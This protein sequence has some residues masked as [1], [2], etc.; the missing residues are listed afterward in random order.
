MSAHRLPLFQGLFVNKRT[1]S[2]QNLVFPSFLSKYPQKASPA[3]V[4]NFPLFFFI[5]HAAESI[6]CSELFFPPP[7]RQ[8]YIALPFLLPIL[9]KSSL[10][11]RRHR[12]HTFILKNHHALYTPRTHF[13]SI[14]QTVD[15]SNINIPQFFHKS[16]FH[17]KAGV[18]T[19]AS[20]F[21]RK[22]RFYPRTNFPWSQETRYNISFIYRSCRS[23]IRQNWVETSRA[24]IGRMALS[25]HTVRQNH[26]LS[27]LISR[28][29]GISYRQRTPREPHIFPSV[30]LSL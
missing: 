11:G 17:V 26:I 14:L 29:T 9:Q 25:A 28:L 27:S 4:F 21:F 6:C 1:F 16:L 7:A 30:L 8:A 18:R 24:G 22:I 10:C 5:K 20:S 19:P 3:A 2:R 23:G 13:L 12:F 15:K